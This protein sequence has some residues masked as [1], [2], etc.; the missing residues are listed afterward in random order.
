MSSTLGRRRSDAAAL[1]MNHH[2]LY[3]QRG[4]LASSHAFPTK[5]LYRCGRTDDWGAVHPDVQHP[6]LAVHDYD[7]SVASHHVSS[8]ARAAGDQ[9][10]AV[11]DR[12]LQLGDCDRRHRAHI[13]DVCTAEWFELQYWIDVSYVHGN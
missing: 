12:D 10:W 7:H 13:S 5:V 1:T 3:A 4:V 11:S 9:Q 6:D 8:R 2:S